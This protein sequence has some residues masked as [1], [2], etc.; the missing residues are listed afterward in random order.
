M[1]NCNPHILIGTHGNKHEAIDF[2]P[3]TKF[4]LRK[5]VH[6]YL[7]IQSVPHRFPKPINQDYS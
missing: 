7:E 3:Q 4:L 6:P 1:W 2:K 5:D